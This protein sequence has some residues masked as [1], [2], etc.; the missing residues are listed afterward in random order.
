ME[1][2]QAVLVRTHAESVHACS[3]QSCIFFAL[4]ATLLSISMGGSFGQLA[5]AAVTAAETAAATGVPDSLAV[6]L[7]EAAQR[8]QGQAS[9]G[10]LVCEQQ[11]IWNK[12]PEA[13]VL[14]HPGNTAKP[15]Y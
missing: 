6:Q 11:V 15:S 5:R 2:E 3:K 7:R 12:Q 14:S 1:C 9:K 13:S 4:Q 10:G 8:V